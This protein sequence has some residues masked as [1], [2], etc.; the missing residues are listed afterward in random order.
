MP[1]GKTSGMALGK[2]E[3]KTDPDVCPA[4]L[5]PAL[6]EGATGGPSLCLAV[7]LVVFRMLVRIRQP[8]IT[9]SRIVRTPTVNVY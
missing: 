3:R 1:G 9:P 4:R 8:E 5:A 7:R 6:T 2:L